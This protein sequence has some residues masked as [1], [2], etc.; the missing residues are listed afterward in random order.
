MPDLQAIYETA[1]WNELWLAY[2]M[3][4]LAEP[5][6]STQSHSLYHNQTR[7]TSAYATVLISDLS[8]I[9]VQVI[10]GVKDK[11]SVSFAVTGGAHFPRFTITL[12][13]VANTEH[14]AEAT[15]IPFSFTPN[16]DP[17]PDVNL[18]LPGVDDLRRKVFHFSKR[19]HQ[20]SV[21]TQPPSEF[22]CLDAKNF[23]KGQV[24]VIDWQHEQVVLHETNKP[25]PPEARDTVENFKR[26]ITTLPRV[27][28]L[29]KPIV[30]RVNLAQVIGIKFF[31]C[32]PIPPPPH[33]WIF[34]QHA[35]LNESPLTSSDPETPEIGN[36]VEAIFRLRHKSWLKHYPQSNS[37]NG[38]QMFTLP[39]IS[40]YIVERQFEIMQNGILRREH[41]FQSLQQPK[42]CNGKYR[43]NLERFESD[44]MKADQCFSAF[45]KRRGDYQ[46]VP[47][48]PQGTFVEITLDTGRTWTAQVVDLGSRDPI[49]IDMIVIIPPSGHGFIVASGDSMAYSGWFR[50]GGWGSQIVRTLSAIRSLM[51]GESWLKE[52]VLAR[53]NLR[54]A[55][56]PLFNSSPLQQASDIFSLN[57]SQRA[58]LKDAVTYDKDVSNR[59]STCRQ[60]IC[61]GPPGTGK[62][63]VILALIVYCLMIK[64]PMLVVAGSNQAVAVITKRLY[65]QLK[66]RKKLDFKIFHLRSQQAEAI[67]RLQHTQPVQ[68][69]E[70]RPEGYRQALRVVQTVARDIPTT[71]SPAAARR[72]EDLVDAQASPDEAPFSLSRY[73]IDRIKALADSL[74][75]PKSPYLGAESEQGL[76]RRFLEAEREATRVQVDGEDD[77]D[78]V[79]GEEGYDARWRALM[80]YYLKEADIILVTADSSGQ[81]ALSAFK[82]AIV[83]IDEASQLRVS[84]VVNATARHVRSWGDSLMS[85]AL[86]GD[87]KQLGPH[88]FSFG[89]NK[90]GALSRESYMEWQV[91]GLRNPTQLLTTQYRSDPEIANFVSQMF[92]DGRVVNAPMVQQ[93]RE[94]EGTWESFATKSLKKFHHNFFLNVAGNHQLWHW[95]EDTSIVNPTTAAVIMKLLARMECHSAINIYSDVQVICFYAAQTSLLSEIMTKAF[96]AGKID[97]RTVDVSQGD[98]KKVLIIDFVRDGREVG[99]FSDERRLCI[100][101]SRA[102]YGMIGVSSADMALPKYGDTGMVRPFNAGEKVLFEYVKMH[103]DGGT[104]IDAQGDTAK[105]LREFVND[106]RGYKLV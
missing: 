79:G 28:V 52:L 27:R 4:A 93:R 56:N 5:G 64:W 104:M 99:F 74:K 58:A 20:L 17:N 101:F 45:V 82:A 53:R 31:L 71:L 77:D 44:R 103:R 46:L 96:P 91:T 13:H 65:V 37:W 41:H 43:F 76:I 78:D 102:E 25:C 22:L 98:Q 83:A 40:Y 94:Y 105:V 72:L 26:F 3:Q 54:P 81:K 39:T 47:P 2:A 8:G 32:Q 59:F 42:T 88:N 80:K 69:L 38:T 75:G 60:S 12:K 1:A 11:L 23:P 30:P 62:T 15:F 87:H 97:L 90:F 57:Q 9:P 63:A 18:A 55:R 51:S 10:K 6:A 33:W 35:V 36:H 89:K 66:N 7:K 50:F 73:I 48:P 84:Q 61:H 29:M 95:G 16:F 49:R 100:A 92:Y 68:Y 67:L 70:A 106:T 14:L 19:I 85:L 21:Y 86:F 24:M 34:G